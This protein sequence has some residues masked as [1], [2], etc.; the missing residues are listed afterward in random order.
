MCRPFGVGGGVWLTGGGTEVVSTVNVTGTVTDAIP[1]ALS[2]IVPLWVPT[3]VVPVITLTM[4]TPLFVPEVR[5][6]LSQAA[7]SLAIQLSVPPPELLMLKVWD[8][9]LAPPC[10]AVKERLAGVAPM[11]AGGTGG[12]V[13]G[14]GDGG[15]GVIGGGGVG[16]APAGI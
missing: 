11:A 1:V 3:A 15:G 4:I 10:V 13:T 7:L 2:V 16:E 6:S 12:G 14:G 9:G 8:V 5:L